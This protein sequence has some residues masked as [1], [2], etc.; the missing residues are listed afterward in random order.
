MVTLSKYILL[1]LCIASFAL[2]A[3]TAFFASRAHSTRPCPAYAISGRKFQSGL[4]A[5]DKAKSF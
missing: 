2:G 3:A 4:V 5:N 1:I